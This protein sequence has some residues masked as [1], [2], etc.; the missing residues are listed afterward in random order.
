MADLSRQDV[1]ARYPLSLFVPPYVRDHVF[2]GKVIFPA[3]EAMIVLARAVK[4]RH[5]QA[6]LF[7]LACASFPRMLEIAPGRDT[8]DVLVEMEVAADWIRASLLTTVRI[9]NATMRRTL[10][11]A[12]VTF[13]QEDDVFQPA[14]DFRTARKLGGA[15]I[16]VPSASIYREL[17]PFGASYQNVIGDLAVSR[18]G[19]FAEVSGGQSPADSLLGSPFTLDAAMHAACVW[20]QRFA[21][22]VTLPVGFA[23]RMI[24]APTHPGRFYP[25]RISPAEARGETLLFDVWIFD[26]EG[27]VCECI[28][29]LG[30]RDVTRGDLRPPQWIGE[31]AWE[32][33]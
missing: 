25:V 4:D 2:Q 21:G 6:A 31:G 1:T 3:V 19:A 9:K 24:V 10:E 15:C 23:G 7:H 20:G 14:A 18:S 27:A 17:I 5:P 13:L 22:R 12:R 16:C 33:S 29:G 8:L 32:N 11:H 26:Q 30:M 28:R